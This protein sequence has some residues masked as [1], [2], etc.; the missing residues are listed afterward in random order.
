MKLIRELP[1]VPQRPVSV[2]RQANDVLVIEGVPYAGE[3][4]R[5]MAL[6]DDEVLLAVHRNESGTVVV[7]EIRNFEQAKRF[8]EEARHAV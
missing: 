6:P 4:F 5:Q 8:F 7:K 1:H 2:E 3:L